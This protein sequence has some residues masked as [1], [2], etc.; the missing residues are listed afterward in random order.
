MFQF[1]NHLHGLWQD[2]LQCV[3]VSHL[4][5]PKLDT[6]LQ[7]PHV[8]RAERKD[9]LPLSDLMQLRTLLLF[10]ARAHGWLIFTLLSTRIPRSFPAKLPVLGHGVLLL[11][12]KTLP[13]D[14]LRQVPEHGTVCSPEVQGCY[15][16][17]SKLT[18]VCS[19]HEAKIICECSFKRASH[20]NTST[21][22]NPKSLQLLLLKTLPVTTLEAK[23]PRESAGISA[24]P[25]KCTCRAQ[26]KMAI[27]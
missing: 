3:H 18:P 27:H 23:V 26:P 11:L 12:P 15:L 25:H 10:T 2:S 8:G 5:S 9:H 21:S 4:G 6:A 16:P 24:K 14:S 19:P 1:C 20:Q 17:C 22:P 13:R 7:M